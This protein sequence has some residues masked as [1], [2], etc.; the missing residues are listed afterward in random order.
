M[1]ARMEEK[2]KEKLTISRSQTVLMSMWSRTNGRNT[3][4]REWS[5]RFFRQRGLR[6]MTNLHSLTT[7]FDRGFHIWG[8]KHAFF[9]HLIINFNQTTISGVLFSMMLRIHCCATLNEIR[10]PQH[11]DVRYSYEKGGI[12]EIAVNFWENL[13]K[14]HM[15][16]TMKEWPQILQREPSP[17]WRVG[18]DGSIFSPFHRKGRRA[19]QF[20]A[21]SSKHQYQYWILKNKSGKYHDLKSFRYTTLTFVQFWFELLHVHSVV[22]ELD[23]RSYFSGMIKNCE[24]WALIIIFIIFFLLITTITTKPLPPS[25]PSS[26]PYHGNT[27]GFRAKSAKPFFSS[28]NHWPS[29]IACL[30]GG[31]ELIRNICFGLTNYK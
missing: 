23:P 20:Q 6:S 27:T 11:N 5:V 12:D 22:L 18:W 10:C 28:S 4:A 16:R 8:Q 31:F 29:L 19:A 14:R 15:M 2:E 25:S 24:H 3:V 21:E 26:S 7:I 1:R 9:C 13:R 30:F 17:L